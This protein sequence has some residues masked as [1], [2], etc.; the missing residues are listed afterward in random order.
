MKRARRRKCK[1]CGGLYDPDARNRRHQRYCSKEECRLVSKAQRQR[2]WLL[3]RENR[4]YFRGPENSERVREWRARNPGY[5]RRKRASGG[6]SLQDVLPP[7]NHDQVA[8]IK[9]Q[10]RSLAGTCVTRRLGGEI[11]TQPLLIIGLIAK[12]TGSTLQDDIEKT[13][14]DLLR[15]GQ[16]IVGRGGKHEGDE[17]SHISDLPLPPRV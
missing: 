11:H 8:E 12:I 16:D 13:S 14:R 5:W 9:E 2:R 3:R 15:L 1:H 4:D 6:V 7:E 10:N 17:A